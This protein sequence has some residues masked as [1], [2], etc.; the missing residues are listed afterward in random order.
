MLPKRPEVT[1]DPQTLI[2]VDG[3]NV[4][5]QL[6]GGSL[7][8]LLGRDTGSVKAVDGVSLRVARGEVLGLVG[9]SGSGKTTLG[10][11][12]LG[13]VQPTSGRIW[14][15]GKNVV[16]LSERQLRGLR[17]K[18]QMVFQ[19]PNAA[20]NP[21]MTIAEQVGHPLTIHQLVSRG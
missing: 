11:A 20:L 3:V 4:H 16:G 2:D 9:E 10:R 18:L 12:L 6:R 5:F 13:L 17:T 8:R 21:A 1:A 15:D 14:Y 7:S 19:D